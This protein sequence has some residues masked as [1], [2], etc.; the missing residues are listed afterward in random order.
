MNIHSFTWSASQP[1]HMSI[2][3]AGGAGKV[4]YLDLSAQAPIDKVTPAI[5]GY[6]SNRKI[7][8]H[9]FKRSRYYYS[10]SVNMDNEA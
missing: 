1:R 8:R 10:Q 3:A 7:N 6:V 4:R 2:S 9:G 5:M